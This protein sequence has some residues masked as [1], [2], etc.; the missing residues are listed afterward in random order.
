MAN[1]PPKTNTPY[2]LT[3]SSPLDG[4]SIILDG[5]SLVEITNLSMVSVT[6]SASHE[7]EFKAAIFKL[8]VGDQ[9]NAVTAHEGRGEKN[10]LFLPSAHGQWFLCFYNDGV[11][12]IDAA[13]SLLGK[14]LSNQLSITD[15]SDAW[16]VLA[17]TGPLVRRTLER[18]CPID[19]SASAMPV[20][21]TA[22]TMIEHLGAIIVRRPDDNDANP[23]FWLLSAR[24]SAS[25]FLH[26]L[27][28]SPPFT[29]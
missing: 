15:Q 19:C 24:S 29:I 25:S 11:D 6:P 3:A 26:A 17:L 27:I 9:L 5:T 13:N 28:A 10:Y 4:H 12:P 14:K 2:T 23:C 20:G 21:T 7:E 18:I 8:F 22:R 16:L 1:T